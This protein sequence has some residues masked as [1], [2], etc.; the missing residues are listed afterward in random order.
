EVNRAI[1]QM[2]EMTQ[3][4]AALVEQAAA[5]AESMQ[6]QAVKLAQ[7]VSV[8]KLDSGG[9]MMTSLPSRQVEPPVQQPASA[10]RV[11]APVKRAAPAR[12]KSPGG[13]GALS[14]TGK[15]NTPAPSSNGDDWEEF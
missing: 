4:N 1:S 11:P 3:Q 10:S 13:G 2:D 15:P 6:E 12:M 7:A 14:P 9:G 8:F 5:A